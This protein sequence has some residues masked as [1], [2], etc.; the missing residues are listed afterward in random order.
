MDNTRPFLSGAF[1]GAG[2]L[3][4]LTHFVWVA[5]THTPSIVP[6][7]SVSDVVETLGAVV[8]GLAANGLVQR[9]KARPA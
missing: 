9:L 3:G 8:C 1:L 5:T 4:V 6:G 2:V 7:L